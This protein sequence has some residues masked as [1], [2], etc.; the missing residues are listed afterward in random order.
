MYLGPLLSSMASDRIL[1]PEKSRHW[2]QF[3]QNILTN[4][5]SFVYVVNHYVCM[6]S[7]KTKYFYI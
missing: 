7:G 2:T 3:S 1:G 6:K 4:S 5:S